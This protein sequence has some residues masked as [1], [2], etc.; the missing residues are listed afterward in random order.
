MPFQ[1]LIL[2]KEVAETGVADFW[3]DDGHLKELA[4]Q[5]LAQDQWSF[6]GIFLHYL[7]KFLEVAGSAGRL[8]MAWVRK[9]K[10]KCEAE[11]TWLVENRLNATG[12]FCVYWGEQDADEKYCKEE[13]AY[14]PQG[15]V[16]ASQ[17]FLM[18]HKLQTLGNSVRK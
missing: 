4:T 2:G 3:P 17:L 16:V 8:D 6:K 7:A 1:Y 15:M 13:V 11:S 5:G 12:G 14:P 10:A 9:L 18:T